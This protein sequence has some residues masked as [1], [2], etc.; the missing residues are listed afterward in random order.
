M[1]G[2][3]RLKNNISLRIS[4]LFNFQ[5]KK[6][7]NIRDLWFWDDN[8]E[9]VIIGKCGNHKRNDNEDLVVEIPMDKLKQ[10]ELL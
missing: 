1:A 3:E 5:N 6:D 4:Y 8:L 2:R 10:W 9:T 7:K